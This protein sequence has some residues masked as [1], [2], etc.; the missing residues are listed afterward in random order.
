MNRVSISIDPI[1]IIMYKSEY[2]FDAG[3]APTKEE[4][5]LEGLQT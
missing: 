5:I 3:N 1:I 2:A 4:E